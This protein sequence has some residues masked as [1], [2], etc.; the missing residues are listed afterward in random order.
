[1]NRKNDYS[2]YRTF[3]RLYGITQLDVLVTLYEV[4][5]L[6]QFLPL[7]PS[8]KEKS[9]LNGLIGVKDDLSYTDYE[10]SNNTFELIRRFQEACYAPCRS[11]LSA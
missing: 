3:A 10:R 2:N 4:E 8:P 11:R 6:L 1:M 5:T 7:N 9:L